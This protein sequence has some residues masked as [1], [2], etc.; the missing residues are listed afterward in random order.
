MKRK[1]TIELIRDIF[2]EGGCTLLSE[3][4]VK[5]SDK[6]EYKCSCGNIS[7]IRI[8]DFEKGQRC[9][10]CGYKKSSS[11]NT[12]EYSEIK[13]YFESQQCTLISEEYVSVGDKLSFICVCGNTGLVSFT[14]FKKMNKC[15]ECGIQIGIEKRKISY[16]I[17]KEIFEENGCVLLSLTYEKCDEKLN[18]ICECGNESEITLTA[19]Q[20][21]SRCKECLRSRKKTTILSYEFVYE[22][23]KENGCTL[24]SEKYE[25]NSKKLKYICI[26]G[27]ESF[28]TFNS[29]HSG[30][31]CKKC[32]IDKFSSAIRLSYDEVKEYFGKQGCI[33]LSETYKNNSS[34]LAYRCVCGNVS[35][36]TL[37][38]F[39]NGSRCKECLSKKL[40]ELRKGIIFPSMRGENHPQ[41]D[42]SK[43]QEEREVSRL[44]PE[45]KPW[46]KSVYERDIYTCQCC[47]DSK[48]GNL[49]AHH[50]DSWDWCKELR[51]DINNGITLCNICH[52]DFHG[53]YGFGGNT[54]DQW[55]EYMDNLLEENPVFELI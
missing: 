21:G 46:R 54:R 26:C 55:D 3:E 6:L 20:R 34:I 42:F 28:I 11:S 18:Y 13:K 33:L 32:G 49:N 40:S 23:F 53:M 47:G 14:E 45:Y 30:R 29:F 10:E 35:E 12:I 2:K 43:T 8:H 36:I 50:L 41:W 37:S 5:S 15:R 51:F 25:G 52:D 17:V 27:D 24:L 22:V 44:L 19:L 7:R 4:Y 48:G 16:E 9:R 31:R 1:F 38:N 39:K